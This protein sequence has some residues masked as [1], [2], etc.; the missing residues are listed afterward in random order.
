VIVEPVHALN[1]RRDGVD[2]RLRSLRGVRTVRHDSA[3]AGGS[4]LTLL[5]A[6]TAVTLDETLALLRE[7]GAGVS[8]VRV[9]EPTL[10][11]AFLAVAG[12]SFE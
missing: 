11:D 10:E 7:A 9:V 3:E 12:R 5:C 2:A 6:D 1:G 4:Q 8:Q